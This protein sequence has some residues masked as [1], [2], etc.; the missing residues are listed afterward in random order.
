MNWIQNLGGVAHWIKPQDSGTYFFYMTFAFQLALNFYLIKL[1][2][3]FIFGS[4][5]IWQ[6]ES[7]L[8][9]LFLHNGHFLIG[10]SKNTLD[11]PMMEI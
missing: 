5:T 2:N 3:L 1:I 10:L 6:K 11:T 4:M 7:R 8:F 9:F